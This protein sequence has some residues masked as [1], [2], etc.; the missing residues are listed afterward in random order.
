ME[1]VY[2][3]AGR[4]VK[5][6][7]P[8]APRPLTSEPA[9]KPRSRIRGARRLPEWAEQAKAL[10][11]SL[12]TIHAVAPYD[13]GSAEQL[14]LETIDSTD[15]LDPKARHLCRICLAVLLKASSR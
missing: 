2:I 4:G 13:T 9:V 3:D 1:R 6:Q 5:R 10:R 14:A 12:R 7:S 8:W 11:A 15:R